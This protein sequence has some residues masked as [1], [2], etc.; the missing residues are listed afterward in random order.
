MLKVIPLGGLG[1]IGLNM[2]ALESED[3]VLVIDA[4]LMFPEEYMLGVDVV[5]PE[6]G[7]LRENRERLQAVVLTHGHEDHIGAMPFLLREFAVPVFGTTFT[8]ALLRE[9]LRE[10]QLSEPPDLRTILPGETAEFGPFLVEFIRVDH[11][12]VDGVGLAVH[13]PEGILVHS[14]DFK[15]DHTP[16]DGIVTDLPRFAHFG[17][18][19]VLALLSDSTNAEK[20]GFTPSERD[21]RR[22]L[23][24]LFR[25]APG[26]I[27]TAVFA[28]NISRIQQ[29]AE[30]ALQGGRKL[31][32]SGKS[33]RSNVRIAR[34]LGLMRIP[35]DELLEERRLV[36]LPDKEIAIITTGS[37][38]E[39][40][41]SLTRMAQN[42]HK[43]IKIRPGDTVIL[44]SRFIPGNEK[45]ITATINSLYRMGAEVVYEKVS[46]I[47][48]SGHAYREE[49]KLMINL[50]R[51]RYFIP[52][53]GEYR[54]LF[55]HAALAEE[56]GIPRERILLA[57]NGD[58]VHFENGRAFLGERIPTGR[59]LVD[60]KG[61]GDVGE[62]VL[63]DRRRL[64]GDGMVIALM[65]VDEQTGDLVYGPDIVSRGFIFE[66]RD[67]A[68]LEDAKCI[69]LEVLDE[70]ERPART[71]WTDI[72]PDI[73]KEL[74]RFFFSVLGR[75]PL[76]LTII[77]PV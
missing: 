46:D 62:V 23:G 45:A 20:E 12:I 32:F 19:G 1:E 47:H 8:I 27:I 17:S 59:V 21:V 25:S 65:A 37:Q 69:V 10:H 36:Q 52:I 11:S 26:R 72:A 51:P 43:H 75:S 70:I 39:P 9:K 44:S 2:M 30:L 67:T 29:V 66:D 7:Y 14:G 74:K 18:L 24:E 33:M 56:V 77:I 42:R 61:V 48:T 31:H 16:V 60:G 41:S 15:V 54:H 4:G 64:S 22:T 68:I 71:D 73:K 3:S 57:E 40:M 28:S 63:R 76:I 35:D 13:T 5:I 34:E 38:G 53:H 6:F 58:T 55:K 49:L 50:V